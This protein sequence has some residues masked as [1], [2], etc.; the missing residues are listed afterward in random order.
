MSN[1]S[2]KRVHLFLFDTYPGPDI[3][4][5]AQVN[6]ADPIVDLFAADDRNSRGIT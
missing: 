3:V 2:D 6:R 4:T 1:S 5:Q